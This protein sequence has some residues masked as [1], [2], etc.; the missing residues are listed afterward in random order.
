MSDTVGRL[1]V[2]IDAKVAQFEQR[3]QRAEQQLQ[4]SAT[5]MVRDAQR[6][7]TSFVSLSGRVTQ[8]ARG[9][10]LLGAAMAGLSLGGISAMAMGAIRAAGDLRDMAQQVGTSTDALQVLQIAATQ[11]GSNAQ[12]AGRGIAALTR[13]IADAASGNEEAQKKF[14]ALGISFRDADGNARGTAAVMGDLADRISRMT[15][16]TEQAAAATALLGTNLGQRL[17]PMLTQGRAGL[18]GVE[19]EARRVGR[20]LSEETIAGAAAATAAFDDLMSTGTSLATVMWSRLAPALESVATALRDVLFG[21]SGA[22]RLSQITREVETLNRLIEMGERNLQGATVGG[23]R[24]LAQSALDR[25]IAQRDAF[26]S[27]AE[28]IRADMERPSPSPTFADRGALPPV[29]DG[30]AGGAGRGAADA[31]ARRR[32]A[33]ALAAE[34]R[35]I[36]ERNRIIES[37]RTPEEAYAA[38]LERLGRLVER[39][40]G[41]DNALPLPTVQAEAVAALND[42]EDAIRRA[43]GAAT[44]AQKALRKLGEQTVMNFAEAAAEGRSL[45]EVAQGLLKDLGRFFLQQAVQGSGVGKIFSSFVGGLFGGGGGG[46]AG[47]V[48]SANGN[49]F[50]GGRL[51]PFATGG[52][53]SGATAFPMADGRTGLM[54]EAGAE[55]IM[56]LTRGPGGKLGVRASGGGGAPVI[57]QTF[58][59]R[60]AMVDEVKMRQIAGQV[61]QQGF[62]RL[63]DQRR[64]SKQVLA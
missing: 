12:E 11:A 38:R 2:V 23:A 50:S 52:V 62:A 29:A 27:E 15:N 39:F 10:P 37:N 51:V 53:V 58:D 8:L 13:V 55:A 31:D 64:E 63:A 49:V 44:E 4:R 43:G 30:R 28:R 34:N 7:D 9:M 17:L 26:L 42:Y 35:A 25:R 48:P 1:T 20:V 32:A 54:G 14:V 19:R 3:V 60:G 47:K 36:A 16:P 45:R 6:V 41:T 57:N 61:T 5:K 46:G 59:F 56:P 18:E 40:E 21:A 24:G 22:T 33:E